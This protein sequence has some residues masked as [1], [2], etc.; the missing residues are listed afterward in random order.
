[1]LKQY[2]LRLYNK[3]Q[4][5]GLISTMRLLNK[6]FVDYLFLELNVIKLKQIGEDSDIKRWIRCFSPNLLEEI[7]KEGLDKLISDTQLDFLSTCGE[8]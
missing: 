4:C 6:T 5:G 8:H 1:M 3:Y 7:G 2:C